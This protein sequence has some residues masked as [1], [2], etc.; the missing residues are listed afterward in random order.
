MLVA[1]THRLLDQHAFVQVVQMSDDVIRHWTVVLISLFIINI[2]TL[3]IAKLVK[4]VIGVFEAILFRLQ[5]FQ[6]LRKR[7]VLVSWTPT[8]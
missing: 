8:L 7:V 3:V 1:T 5:L 6:V 2:A 4:I